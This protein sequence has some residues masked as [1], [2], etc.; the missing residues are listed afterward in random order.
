MIKYA[1]AAAVTLSAH[2]AFGQ[3]AA[4]PALPNYIP[5]TCI[6]N[7]NDPY[8]TNTKMSAG[9]QKGMCVHPLFRRSVKIIQGAEA[10]RYF[11]PIGEG[12]IVIANFSHQGR[13][14]AAKIPAASVERMILQVQ[15]FPITFGI[16]VDVAHTQLRFDFAEGRRIELVEQELKQNPERTSLAH[17]ILSD[18]NVGPYGEKFDAF[19]GVRGYYN[20]AYRAVSVNDKYD[21]MIRKQNHQVAQYKFNLTPDQVRKVL[22][23]N[24]KFGTYA[25][26][27]REYNTLSQNCANEMIRIVDRALGRPG[28][29]TPSI[30]NLA[31]NA[32]RSRKMLSEEKWPTL[33]DEY[34]KLH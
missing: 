11:G 26:V 29:Y 17:M 1:F 31:I 16:T 19:K 3:A 34:A 15:Y 9:P 13:F 23:Y 6:V 21:W 27:T 8:E 24:L 14:W 10:Q 22:T 5:G 18:E 25:G 30:P 7:V 2:L 32:F 4:L 20:I 33:N 12:D 28:G